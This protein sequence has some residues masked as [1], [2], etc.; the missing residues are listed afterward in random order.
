MP[1][2]EIPT[3]TTP[4]TSV[5]LIPAAVTPPAAPPATPPRAAD[6]G[7]VS[8]SSEALSTR[9]KE[10]RAKERKTFLKS[11][12]FDSEEAFATAMKVAKEAADAK[13]SADEKTALR[14]KELEPKAERAT[15]L[16][17]R[18]AADVKRRL[19]RLDEATQAKI[20]KAAGE[21]PSADDLD[22]YIS[23]FE[24]EDGA[25]AAAA[26]P[27]AKKVADAA[28]STTTAKPAPADGGGALTAFET[29]HAK[30]ASDPAAAAIYLSCNG[31]AIN[32][33][34]PPATK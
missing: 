18:F 28:K 21:D 15:K 31:A 34:R 33:T 7:Q 9:L 1:P 14:I 8:M 29:Y 13:L 6:D 19:G 27:A 2:E 4:P 10:E 17:A 23:L 5:P 22:K 26:A 25:P 32:A 24:P 3:P 20:T 12:G 16:E 11:N 30:L